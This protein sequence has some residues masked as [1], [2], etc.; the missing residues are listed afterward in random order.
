MRMTNGERTPG[1][2]R[3]RSIRPWTTRQ[4]LVSLALAVLGLALAATGVRAVFTT[5][6]DTGAAALLTV[7]TILV[8]FAA[9]GDRLTSLRYGDLELVLRDKADEAKRRGDV[10]AAEVLERAADTVGH[11]VARVARSYETV[12]GSMPAGP[13]RTAMMDRIID[14]A[15]RDAEA[16]DLDPEEVLRLL[17]TGSEGAR[18][19]ALGVLQ[20][21]PELAT[22]RAVLE[23]VQRPDQMFDQYHALLL[24]ERFVSLPATRKWARERIADAVQ[25]QIRKLGT[26]S[27]SH[28]AARRVLEQ[29]KKRESE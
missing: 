24:A 18:V 8:L 11:R 15:K 13:E 4:R 14:E 28:E 26:N 27:S 20:A 25:A 23:A 22:T 3:T 6:S 16:P 5:D 17:W 9:L 21:R 7:G 12:R 1:S 2:A 10:E 29:V 19:W